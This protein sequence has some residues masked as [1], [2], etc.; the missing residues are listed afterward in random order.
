MSDEIFEQTFQVS[1]PANL[2]VNNICGSVEIQTGEDGVIRVT[3]T[4]RSHTGDEKRTEIEIKQESDGTVKASTR[5]PDGSWNWLFGS[6]PCDVDYVVK[7]PRQCSLKLNGVSN[8]VK[9]A[10]FDG[11]VSVN[12]VSGDIT[13]RDLNGSV[14]IHTV[15]GDAE[16]ENIRGSLDLET[17]SGDAAFNKSA[18]VSVKANTVSGDMRI[19]SA[20]SDG[21]YNFKSVSGD[22]RL[23]VPP[24]TCCTSELHSVSGDL[25]SAFPVTNFSRHHGSQ[26]INVQGGGVKIYLNSVS[27]DLS[28]ECDGEIPHA[29]NAAKN[30]SK[31]DRRAV[32][33]KLEHGEMTVEDALGK[34]NS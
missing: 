26:M 7:A 18:L 15:S 25:V 17:V 19:H 34:L 14:R 27:G 24:E 4:K 28:L 23:I 33:E 8:S 21:P 20:L 10:G 31:E 13:L 30:T 22:V 1:G 29:A 5:F 11:S 3:A 16:T 2:S 12:T 9:A 32:L 6:R